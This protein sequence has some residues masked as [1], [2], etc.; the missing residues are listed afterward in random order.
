MSESASQWTH[1]ELNR[2]TLKYLRAST[3]PDNG[4]IC[5]SS[6]HERVKAMLHDLVVAVLERRETSESEP[7]PNS[8]STA[9]WQKALRTALRAT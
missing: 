7:V 5:H 2:A 4:L 9:Q 3:T 1:Q 6:T 8:I